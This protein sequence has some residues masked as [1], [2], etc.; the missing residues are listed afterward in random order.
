LERS[1]RSRARFRG[2]AQG[3][4]C[5]PLA[6]CFRRGARRLSTR[7]RRLAATPPSLERD[8]SELELLLATSQMIAAT[9]GSTSPDRVEINARAA[10]LAAK[11]GNLGHL[12]EQIFG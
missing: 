10:D 4:R 11:T 12:A 1:L 6:Q 5:R 9:R 2:V 3:W 7:A 8:A